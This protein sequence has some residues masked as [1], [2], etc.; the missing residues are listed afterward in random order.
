MWIK[1]F[2]RLLFPLNPDEMR[3][4]EAIQ[5]KHRH[6]PNAL[7][8]Y[9]SLSEYSLDN[10]K[11]ERERLSY[12]SEFN[13]P[14]DA[15][16][17][18]NYA[19]LSKELFLHRNM[20]KILI[21]LQNKLGISLSDQAIREIRNSE[22][23]FY[24]FSKHVARFDETLHGK[25]EDFARSLSEI[26]LEQI[27]SIFAQF[28]S[29][30]QTGYLVMCL[31]EVKD[32][33]LMWSHYSENHTGFCIEYNFKE[34]GPLNPQ[35][36]MLFPINYTDDLFDATQYIL[37]P[38]IRR[39]HSFNNLFGIY[40]TITKSTHWAY[41]KEWRIVFPLGPNA[42]EEQRFIKLPK[43]KALYI[44]AKASAE[45]IGRLKEI[46]IIKK[47]PLFQMMLSETS[48]VLVQKMLYHPNQQ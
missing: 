36:R 23:P 15:S 45:N 2:L 10:L 27:K 28:R 37:Q 46:A 12:P 17:K 42:S 38:L 5:L 32:S 33:I 19:L 1:E 11:N 16:I 7:Y 29:S 47:I 25:E 21:E 35:S 43:P 41:E 22:D 44:G 13:D 26:T 39:D 31:S 34:L 4:E 9:R 18:I 6:I 30:F 20:Q 48:Y 14:F 3:I 24:S 40:P 8:R